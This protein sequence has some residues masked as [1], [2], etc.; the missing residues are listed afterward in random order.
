[1][2]NEQMMLSDIKL[3]EKLA[4]IFIKIMAERIRQHETWGE[5]NHPMISDPFT[6]E[7]MKIGENFYRG[8]NLYGKDSSWFAILMEEVCEAFAETEMEKQREELIQCCAVIVQ[9]IEYLDR[10]KEVAVV[11]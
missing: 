1:M 9:I 7:Q 10:V 5:Q 11:T 8:I 4:P 6:K 3:S 2:N